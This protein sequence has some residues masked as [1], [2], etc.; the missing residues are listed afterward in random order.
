MRTCDPAQRLE[1]GEIASRQITDTGEAMR[2]K[3]FLFVALAAGLLILTPGL[4]VGT[5]GFLSAR[6]KKPLISPDDPTTK[7]FN[8]LD[9][10][11]D[12][13]LENFYALADVYKNPAHPGQDWQHILRVDYNKKLFFGKFK[14]YVCG[15]SKPT[16]D[17]L[18]A[19]TL[20][21]LYDFGSDSEKYEKIA[22]GPF[23][24]KGDLYFRAEENMPLATAPITPEVEAAYE[25]YVTQFLIPALEKTKKT[26]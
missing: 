21:Q 25:A 9:T 20:K 24:Q 16:P 7:L 26:D 2:K 4:P 15:I 23:G 3:H 11:F 8:L 22:V 14:F 10:K 1:C 12:G 18:K 6:E 13:K 19:Y 17:Q 5:T